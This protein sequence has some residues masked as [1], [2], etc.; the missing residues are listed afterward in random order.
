V[1]VVK[2]CPRTEVG[3]VKDDGLQV[4]V[5]AVAIRLQEDGVVPEERKKKLEDVE[6]LNWSELGPSTKLHTSK[7]EK[8]NIIVGELL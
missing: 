8:N 5:D 6:K 7:Q 1:P 2:L 4:R 3:G